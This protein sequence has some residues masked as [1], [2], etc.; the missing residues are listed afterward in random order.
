MSPTCEVSARAARESLWLHA[1]K[2][3]QFDEA[4]RALVEAMRAGVPEFRGRL[5]VKAVSGHAGVFEMT[6]EY[7]EGRA[8]VEL[9]AGRL[10]GERHVIWRRIGGSLDLQRSVARPG[11]R[12][13]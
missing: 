2:R 7:R 9:G 13:I 12:S 4:R 6:W 1:A 3:C 5:R 11:V 10:P 8:R